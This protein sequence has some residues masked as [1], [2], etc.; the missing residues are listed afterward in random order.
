MR[1]FGNK[2]RFFNSQGGYTLIEAVLVILITTILSVVVIDIIYLQVV[3]F[4]QVFDRSL[5]LGEWRKALW[6]MRS[7]VQE[8]D[9]D[10][11]TT[12]NSNRLTFNDFDGQTI[13][14][15]YALNTLNRNGVKVAEWLQSDPFQ[16]LD[17]NQNVTA[18]SDSLTFIRV[19]LNFN[20]NDSPVQLSE[21]LYLR[22]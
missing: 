16:Y 4:N 2:I 1:N 17:D 20:R 15:E 11:I 18:N 19:T 10:N 21:L 9:P 6:Q 3:N 22:N 7:E 8:I 14:Y 12:M 5:L 13:D